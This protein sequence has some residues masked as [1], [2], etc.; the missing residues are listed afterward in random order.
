M[1]VSP[2]PQS[3]AAGILELFAKPDLA[4]QL[5][6]NGRR[7]VANELTVDKVV[8]RLETIYQGAHTD[9]SSASTHTVIG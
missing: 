5:S 2:N 8:T 6:E 4:T 9:V 3:I 1:V 7:L